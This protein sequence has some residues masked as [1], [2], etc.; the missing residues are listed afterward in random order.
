MDKSRLCS[1]LGNAYCLH[2]EERHIE[3]SHHNYHAI[4]R[5]IKS[6]SF[7][8]YAEKAFFYHYVDGSLGAYLA[9]LE[10]RHQFVSS[11]AGAFLL[12]LYQNE[13]RFAP[14]LLPVDVE[15]SQ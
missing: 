14:D 8:T 4:K 3:G 5:R 7:T 11:P 13:Q 10:K 12:P 2:L 9:S 6:G 1:G 15:V